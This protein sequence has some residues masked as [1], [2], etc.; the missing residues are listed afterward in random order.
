MLKSKILIVEDEWIIAND[1]KSSLRNL[2]YDVVAVTATGEEAVLQSSMKSPD[3]VLMDIVLQGEIDGIETAGQIMSRLDIPVV[4]LT[5]YTDNDV[6]KQAKK[7]GAYGYLVKPFKDREMQATIEMALYKHKMEKKLKQS[8]SRLFTTLRSIN[9]AVI[10]TDKD[11][12]ITFMNPVA[13]SLTGYK[14]ESAKG[15]HLRDIFII[16]YIEPELLNITLDNIIKDGLEI[17]QAKY[18][19][20]NNDN[21]PVNIELSSAPITDDKDNMSGLVIVFRDISRRIQTENE[22]EEYR[23]QLEQIAIE[24]T[25]KLKLF[26]DIVE[27]SPDGVQIIDLNG[28]I[29]YANNAVEKIYGYSGDELKGRHVNEVNEDP[30]FASEVILPSIR[31]YGQWD[32]EL[33]VKHKSG[34][35]FPVWLAAFMVND[36]NN[37]PTGI[38]SIIRDLSDRKKAEQTIKDSEEKFRTL[39]NQATDS[40]FLLSFSGSELIIEDTNAAA[41]KCYGYAREDLIGKPISILDD[42]TTQNKIPER[43]NR[44][45]KGKL[46]NFEASH[47]RKDGT[48][49]PVEVSAQLIHIGKK[50]FIMAFDRDITDRKLSEETLLKYH[51]QLEDLVKE[52]TLELME[53]NNNLHFEIVERKKAE[54]KL[55][56][57][58]KQLQSLTSQLSLFEENEK[59][60]IATELHDCVGQTLALSKIKLGLLNKSV[61]TPDLKSSINEIL[62][63]IEQTIKETRTLTFELSPPILY[64]LGLNQAIQWL[65]DQFSVK[66][67]LNIILEHNGFDMPYDNNVRF[68]LF[69]AIRE[70]LFNIVKHAKATKVKITMSGSKQNLQINVEDNGV[71]FTKPPRNHDGFGLFNIRERMNHINGKFEIKSNPDKGTRVTLVAP[72]KANKKIH[73]KELR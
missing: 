1:I 58:Q 35:A 54:K 72:L 57:Y 68:F 48:S 69:Q 39:F 13:R 2:G 67:G 59:R 31:T 30:G 29:L 41:L 33:M 45:L 60:R 37:Q 24:R 17:E 14:A 12:M 8:E 34:N 16:K 51:E 71:G 43:T 50:P 73:E 19:L 25:A 18:I 56:D 46:L 27:K 62:Q 65:I 36:N 66:H 70:L 40:I 32:G 23:R 26:S 53:A 63:L 10:S 52:R 49:F 4:Y 20:F 6:L 21:V 47:A 7:S 61:H 55:L 15:N 42:I 9:D 28:Q 64:E 11:G 5:A 3:I 22:L 44:L 38:I